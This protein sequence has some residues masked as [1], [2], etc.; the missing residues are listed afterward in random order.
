MWRMT[1]GIGS[2]ISPCDTSSLFLSHSLT[3]WFVNGTVVRKQDKGLA[4]LDPL[5][6]VPTSTGD[7]IRAAVNHALSPAT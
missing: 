6:P 1:N 5:T 2:G 4:F 7:R 3:R